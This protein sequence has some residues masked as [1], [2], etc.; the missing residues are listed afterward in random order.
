ML[1]I[2]YIQTSP[3]GERSKSSKVANHFID[4]Y[5]KSNPDDTVDTLNVFDENLP[6]F[7][8]FAVQ[9]RYNIMHRM[10]HS[11]EQLEAWKEIE[12]I[13][14]RFKD[15]D[16]Y[17][18]SLPMWNF[19]IPYRLKQYLDIILQPG[20]TFTVDENGYDGLIKNKPVTI[21]YSRGGDYTEGSERE[22]FDM[23]K[24][25]VET[26]FGF[27]GFK[28]I[29]SIVVEPTLMYG[30]DKSAEIVQQAVEKAEELAKNF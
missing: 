2:L 13:I 6:S 11:T 28:N 23:Q 3:R 15:A 1:N 25:Y 4:S 14:A 7:D 5:K 12:D 24:K 21:I 29:S 27:M 20:Y 22:A 30:P 10:D 16:K 18:V 8:G 26:A 17:L 9:A 19:S